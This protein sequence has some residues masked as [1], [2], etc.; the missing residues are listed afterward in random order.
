M[1]IAPS[2]LRCISV[3]RFVNVTLDTPL[4]VPSSMPEHDVVSTMFHRFSPCLGSN[5]RSKGAVFNRPIASE[6][7]PYLRQGKLISEPLEEGFEPLADRFSPANGLVAGWKP[8][9]IVG[10]K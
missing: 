10:K 4:I 7:A 3:L 5:F 6:P 2:L 9:Y 8:D 1:M